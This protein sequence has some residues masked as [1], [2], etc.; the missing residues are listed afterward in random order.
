MTAKRK[1]DCSVTDLYEYTQSLPITKLMFKD[2]KSEGIKA[3][4]YLGKP[5]MLCWNPKISELCVFRV[6]PE[7]LC[8]KTQV[9]SLIAATALEKHFAFRTKVIYTPYHSYFIPNHRLLEL[10]SMM[11]QQ[12]FYKL[13]KIPVGEKN[14]DFCATI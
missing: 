10:S 4:D 13:T 1:S 2:V 3:D 6:F 14:M 11:V 8:Y 9:T 7:L 5:W 12:C